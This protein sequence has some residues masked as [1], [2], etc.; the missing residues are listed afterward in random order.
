[1]SARECYM[2]SS[3]LCPSSEYQRISLTNYYGLIHC[4]KAAHARHAFVRSSLCATT[5]YSACR[6][7]ACYTGSPRMCVCVLDFKVAAV[8]APRRS[9]QLITVCRQ[10]VHSTRCTNEEVFLNAAFLSFFFSYFFKYFF[11]SFRSVAVFSSANHFRV[12]I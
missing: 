11:F 9:L 2:G 12:E 5:P 10:L 7:T 1:M 3:S 4:G 8:W 6:S